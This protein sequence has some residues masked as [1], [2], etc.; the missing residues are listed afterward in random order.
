MN[1]R[2]LSFRFL[3]FLMVVIPLFLPGWFYYFNYYG[4]KFGW[5]R[6]RYPKFLCRFMFWYAKASN[7]DVLND[8]VRNDLKDSKTHPQT[9]VLMIIDIL[10]WITSIV[11]FVISNHVNVN[12]FNEIFLGVFSISSFLYNVLAMPIFLLILKI[13][14]KRK[15]KKNK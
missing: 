14:D 5:K 4:H 10:I 7:Q 15:Q 8:P 9:V 11:L 3:Y 2:I 13:I 1:S 6:I 12:F